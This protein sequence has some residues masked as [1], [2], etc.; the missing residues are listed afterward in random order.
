MAWPGPDP[1]TFFRSLIDDVDA[2]LGD[3]LSRRASLTAAVQPYKPVA[4]RD[5]ARERAI[6]DAVA[7]RAPDLGRDRVARIVHAIITESLDAAK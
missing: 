3:L 6:V 5:P 7:A 2:H 1:L 4:E